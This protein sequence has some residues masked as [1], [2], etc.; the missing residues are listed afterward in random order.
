MNDNPVTL[1]SRIRTTAILVN[2]TDGCLKADIEKFGL[3]HNT[4]HTLSE[5]HSDKNIAEERWRAETN[6]YMTQ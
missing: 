4:T 6:L 3:T 1:L 2:V 5:V